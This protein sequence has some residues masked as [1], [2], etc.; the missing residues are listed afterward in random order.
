MSE[1]SSTSPSPASVVDKL[2]DD[3]S[4]TSIRPGGSGPGRRFNDRDRSGYRPDYRNSGYDKSRG[5][6]DRDGRDGRDRRDDRRDGDRDRRGGRAGG[7]GG[8]RRYSRDSFQKLA[9]QPRAPSP[10]KDEAKAA[11]DAAAAA[12]AAAATAAAAEIKDDPNWKDKVARPP[13]DT[14]ITTEDVK[15]KKGLDFED[16]SLKREVLKGIWEMGWVKPSP[17][18]EEAIPI[19]LMNKSILARAKNGTGKTASFAIPCIE[20]ADVTKPYT[21]VLVC[22]PTRELALQTSAVLRSLAKY[23]PE[24]TIVVTTGGT[25]LKDDIIRLM[26]PTHILVCTPGRMV[27]L[28]NKRVADLSK[29]TTFVMDEADKLLSEE[30]EP[31]I[32]RLLSYTPSNRQV[33]CLS[34]TYP[35]AVA[36]F[37]TKWLKDAYE[38]NL[39][40]ELTLKGV[41]QYYAF[42]DEKHKVHCLNTLFQKLNI[43]QCI[44][45]CNSVT[46]VELLAKKIAELGSSCFYIH[47]QMRQDDRNRVFHDF[48]NGACRNLVCSDLI[49]RG[50]DIPTCNVV[51]NFDFP[52]SAET[53]LHR[54]GRSGRFGHLGLAINMITFDDRFNMYKIEQELGTEITPIPPV[55]DKDL[56]CA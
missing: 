39:M 55:I 24:L 17:I 12:A 53:Y 34:A 25:D 18:Q 5:Y 36:D 14:R 30:F 42:V 13:A 1:G 7:R 47:A 15:S 48:R 49:T 43:N 4:R 38:I 28:T 33:I 21:Q 51:I 31:L 41:T 22:V 27:D 35:R 3:F 2:S 16:F 52:K 26:K 23:I 46:R 32:D 20:K 29:C 40:D 11:S 56:Y 54:V 37:K 45:F 9:A 10:A 8:G 50:I 19:A 6:G 44:I